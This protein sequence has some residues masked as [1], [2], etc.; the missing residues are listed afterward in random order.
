MLI[1]P[2]RVCVVAH[3]DRIEEPNHDRA[4]P[5]HPVLERRASR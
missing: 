4:E 5:E 1:E 2:F 3:A